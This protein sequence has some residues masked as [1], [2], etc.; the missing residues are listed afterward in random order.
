MIESFV[1]EI[2]LLGDD[3]GFVGWR[4]YQQFLDA[5]P[6]VSSMSCHYSV[7]SE[8][9]T[10][11]PPHAHVEEELLI[12]LDG[13][14]EL[15]VA[16]SPSDP[17]PRREPVSPGKFVYYP[18]WQHHTIRNS[19]N[20]SVTYLMFKW[21]GQHLDMGAND[22]MAGSA[23]ADGPLLG[24]DIFG[25]RPALAGIHD[26]G[27]SS[28]IVFEGRTPTLGKLHC[29]LT[30]LG[31]GAGYPAHEDPYDVAI[32]LLRGRIKINGQTIVK[33]GIA[34]FSAGVLHDMYNPGNLGAA[35]LVFEFHPL[36][37]DG[38]LSCWDASLLTQMLP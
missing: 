17:N 22:R 23:V 20:S 36:A 19:S 30:K 34:Y 1:R 2:D 24:A 11:H 25:I 18:A 28:T 16:S 7:L 38:P 4:P 15:V 12:I 10:P 8:G 27:F 31:P 6:S 26:A 33:S 9:Q 13:E 21:A 5:T 14:A 29:H 3:P 35:Y 37:L 32:V